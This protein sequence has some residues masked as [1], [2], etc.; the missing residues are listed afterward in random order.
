MNNLEKRFKNAIAMCK[1]GSFDVGSFDVPVPVAFVQN[2]AP[3]D[4]LTW[5][6]DD[7]GPDDQPFDDEEITKGSSVGFELTYDE[8][9][10][11]YHSIVVRDGDG[12]A[13]GVPLSIDKLFSL[14]Q[15]ALSNGLCQLDFLSQQG[16]NL[17]AMADNY[18]MK[19]VTATIERLKQTAIA[20][21]AA[22]VDK[23]AMIEYAKAYNERMD[24][25]LA[26]KEAAL[27]LELEKEY[28]LP[29][30]KMAEAVASGDDSLLDDPILTNALTRAKKRYGST[31]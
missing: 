19:E 27:R 24:K 13:M 21:V 30:L 16:G 2:K 9:G 8:E 18:A 6:P 3:E 10:A 1:Y 5:L 25:K 23:A 15:W 12:F 26:A 29:L 11:V 7:T 17:G 28:S 14:A 4:Q 20:P 31:D 22:A